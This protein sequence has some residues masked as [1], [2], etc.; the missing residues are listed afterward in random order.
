[1]ALPKYPVGKKASLADD[2]LSAV[3]RRMD[4]TAPTGARV[5]S[6]EPVDEDQRKAERLAQQYAKSDSKGPPKPKATKPSQGFSMDETESD[7]NKGLA[8]ITLSRI[9]ARKEAA[10]NIAEGDRVLRE[11]TGKVDRMMTS[12][13]APKEEAPATKYRPAFEG[14]TAKSIIEGPQKVAQP[15]SDSELMPNINVRDIATRATTPQYKDTA[16]MASSPVPENMRTPDRDFDALFKKATGTSFNSKNATDR[17]RMAE[18]QSLLSS[19]ADLA[20][21]SDT[22]VALAWYANKRKK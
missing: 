5:K 19:R 20:D 11:A 14:V 4:Y 2:F 17:A 6:K 10:D 13:P 15:K 21:K 8:P 3:N 12:S 16:S 18:L 1:M 22:K 9:G 7:F